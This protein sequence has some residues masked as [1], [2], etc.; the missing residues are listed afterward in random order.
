MG[1]IPSLHSRESEYFTPF[2]SSRRRSNREYGA[3]LAFPRKEGDGSESVRDAET[4]VS[5]RFVLSS[6]NQ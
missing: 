1:E 2:H 4:R 3:V 6:E 5:R